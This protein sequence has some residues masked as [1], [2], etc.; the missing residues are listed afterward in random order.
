MGSG[1][2]FISHLIRPDAGVE[3]MTFL[4]YRVLATHT[5]IF[6]LNNSQLQAK[7]E[8]FQSEIAARA[9]EGAKTGQKPGE[10]GNH[11]PA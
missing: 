2:G 6:P 3:C 8:N 1:A 4:P 7:S 9:E 10:E 11:E 5:W